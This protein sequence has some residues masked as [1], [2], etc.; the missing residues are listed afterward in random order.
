MTLVD[1]AAEIGIDVGVS[2]EVDGEWS[3]AMTWLVLMRWVTKRLMMARVAW[4]LLL[5]MRR[6]RQR[7][8]RAGSVIRGQT[9]R[10]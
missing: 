8:L 1:W 3:D 7:R 5:R 9:I 2:S 6:W 4:W 10:K